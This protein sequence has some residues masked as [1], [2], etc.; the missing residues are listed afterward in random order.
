MGRQSRQ[1][2]AMVTAIRD[3][4]RLRNPKEVWL[5]SQQVVPHSNLSTV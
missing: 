4:G 5:L 2:Q 3:G 1:Q